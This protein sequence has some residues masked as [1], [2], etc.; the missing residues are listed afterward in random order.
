M[1]RLMNL[2]SV[3]TNSKICKIKFLET[4]FLK[5]HVCAT[6]KAWDNCFTASG[7]Y[8]SSLCD[9]SGSGVFYIINNKDKINQKLIL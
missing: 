3:K 8:I 7:K 4:S 1:K 9:N 5:N 2:S 6:V